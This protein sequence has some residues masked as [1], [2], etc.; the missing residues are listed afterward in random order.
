M[1]KWLGMV[2]LGKTNMK[3][4][5]QAVTIDSYG[6]ASECTTH[7]AWCTKLYISWVAIATSCKFIL[8]TLILVNIN[9]YIFRISI[10]VSLSQRQKM[11]VVVVFVVACI[12]M[13]LANRYVDQKMEIRRRNPVVYNQ[14]LNKW[15]KQ[16]SRLQQKYDE[17]RYYCINILIGF[18]ALKGGTYRP[19]G[20]RSRMMY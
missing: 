15:D 18:G 10:T 7:P 4:W 8:R 12:M 11:K 1:L 16:T 5:L 9:H 17:G 19:H 20:H 3:H 13:A 6:W 14:A 2:A